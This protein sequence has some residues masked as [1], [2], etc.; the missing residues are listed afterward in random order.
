MS[1]ADMVTITMQKGG[2]SGTARG[3]SRVL[4]FG[5]GP[6][7]HAREAQPELLVLGGDPL[8]RGL[9]RHE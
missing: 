2:G 9:Y 8:D 5:L 3:K 4:Y 6:R 1:S 7:P